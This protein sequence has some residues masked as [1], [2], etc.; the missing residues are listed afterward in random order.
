MPAGRPSEYDHE[1][2]ADICTLISSSTDSLEKICASDER[3][4]AL[5]TFYRWKLLHPELQQEYAHAKEEQL[6]ILADELTA[7]ADETHPGEI[8]TL[9]ADGSR[10][11]K[12]LDATEHRR[13][14]ID[15][16][17]WLLSKLAPKKYGDKQDLTVTGEIVKRV[18][19][20]L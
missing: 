1:I 13:I 19:S 17:K 6:E 4:P 20:D 10:E 2:A 11:V 7:I 16:R 15:T 18:V 8:I 9:K 5:R 14:R 12:I 3:F